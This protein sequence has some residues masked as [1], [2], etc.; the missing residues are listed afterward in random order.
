MSQIDPGIGLALH[1]QEN[2]FFT[3]RLLGLSQ[4]H[5]ALNAVAHRDKLIELSNL[6]DDGSRIELPER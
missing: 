3:D 1:H 5:Y 2:R 4:A 6:R